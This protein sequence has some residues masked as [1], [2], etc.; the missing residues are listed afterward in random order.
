M[1]QLRDA[2]GVKSKMSFLSFSFH[3]SQ[4]SEMLKSDC[5]KNAHVHNKLVFGT[6]NL[7]HKEPNLTF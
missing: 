2:S 4:R 6:T 7:L 3:S 1:S 5:R